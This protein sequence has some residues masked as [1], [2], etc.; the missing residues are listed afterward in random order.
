[1]DRREAPITPHTAT[2]E[3]VTL[4][5]HSSTLPTLL[6]RSRPI[7]AEFLDSLDSANTREAYRRDLENWLQF[8]AVHSVDPMQAVRAD[9]RTWQQQNSSEQSPATVARRTAAVRSFYRYTVEE[10]LL[11]KNPA[12]HLRAPRVDNDSSTNPLSS[13]E[14]LRLLDAARAHSHTAT[15]LLGLLL[16]CALRVSEALSVTAEDI[17]QQEAHRVLRVFG[18][19]A[20]LRRVPLS[21]TVLELLAPIPSSGLLVV[22]PKGGTLNRANATRLLAQLSQSAA[23]P[24]GKVSPHVL[25]HTAATLALDSGAPVQRVADLLGHSSPSTTMRYVQARERLSGSAAYLLGAVLSS[26]PTV[27]D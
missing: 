9:L 5:Q 4:E 11:E 1:M 10:G 15:T 23:L 22:G 26:S 20:K 8:C 19:G 14:A 2:G 7:G 27:S 25:R 21:P 17:E 18:K 6:E 3:T 24:R 13:A 12:Q 16:G